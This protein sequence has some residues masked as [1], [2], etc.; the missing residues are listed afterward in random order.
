MKRTRKYADITQKQNEESLRA[1]LLKY[2]NFV[3]DL[4]LDISLDAE[5]NG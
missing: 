4:I 2:R 1:L 5:K 3:P